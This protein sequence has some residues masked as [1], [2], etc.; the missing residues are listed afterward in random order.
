V[1]LYTSFYFEDCLSFCTCVLVV[2]DILLTLDVEC[3][4]IWKKRI[5]RWPVTTYLYLLGRYP[6]VIG[7]YSRLFFMILTSVT[8]PTCDVLFKL[9]ASMVLITSAANIALLTLRVCAIYRWSKP[10]IALFTVLGLSRLIAGGLRD[11]AFTNVIVT[12]RPIFGGCDESIGRS[13]TIAQSADSILVL[14]FDTSI[15]VFT[16]RRTLYQVLEARRTENEVKYS[17]LLLRDGTLYFLP[18]TTFNTFNVLYILLKPHT[19]LPN[20]TVFLSVMNMP[21]QSVLVSRL[22]LNLKRASERYEAYP[23]ALATVPVDFRN[24]GYADTIFGNLTMPL[25]LP[26][27][28][29]DDYDDRERFVGARGGKPC[30]PPLNAYTTFASDESDVELCVPS[31]SRL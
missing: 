12:E 11:F 5:S 21:M 2:Y 4:L 24:N 8:V 30:P 17:Y 15:F 19:A 20:I 1:G 28:E 26:G 6:S 10:V 22:M 7:W 16:I 18:L 3:S 27:D 13:F 14:L 31:G 23:S 9:N 25:Y 29:L